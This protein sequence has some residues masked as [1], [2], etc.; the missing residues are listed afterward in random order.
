MLHIRVKT[1]LT[2]FFVC[3][4]FLAFGPGSVFAVSSDNDLDREIIQ[5]DFSVSR[6]KFTSFYENSLIRFYFKQVD[7]AYRDLLISTRRDNFRGYCAMYVNNLLV[8]FGINHN[9]IKGNANT[10]YSQ[11]SAMS[12]TDNGY[13]IESISAKEHTLKESLAL[14]SDPECPVEKI[15]V[16]FSKGAT[17]KG[18]EFGH[19]FYVNA[20]IEDTVVF[21]ESSPSIFPDRTVPDG[22][23]MALTIDDICNK[24]DYY[25]FE[26][27]IYFSSISEEPSYSD[28]WYN[29]SCRYAL[30]DVCHYR[31][32]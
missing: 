15:L 26:G 32:K 6:D 12:Y 21:S 29:A 7:K 23:P 28:Y 9:Y 17:E 24:Y 22:K 4:M 20:L 10:L 18:K 19:V 27:I 16:I 25:K 13:F 30:A 2:L 1:S 8:Y 14:L 3:I 31:R 5:N 11:Y